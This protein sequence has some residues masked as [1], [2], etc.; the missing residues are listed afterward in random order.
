MKRVIIFFLA[1][2]FA[3]F[4]VSR[5]DDWKEYYRDSNAVYSYRDIKQLPDSKREVV[6]VMEIGYACAYN[7][8][9]INCKTKQ[10]FQIERTAVICETTPVWESGLQEWID[11]DKSDIFYTEKKRLIANVCGGT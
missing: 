8:Y 2:M 10:W 5:S 6:T 3:G 11:L 1:F 7:H 4:N 9:R